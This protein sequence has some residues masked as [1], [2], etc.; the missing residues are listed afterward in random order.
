M[1][2]AVEQMFKELEGLAPDASLVG[3]CAELPGVVLGRV[4][5]KVLDHQDSRYAEAVGR[6]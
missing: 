2:Q 5:G 4:Q 6:Y 1:V 3:A